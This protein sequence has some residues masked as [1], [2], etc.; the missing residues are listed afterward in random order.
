MDYQSDVAWLRG[1]AKNGSF[2]STQPERVL[3]RLLTMTAD[4]SRFGFRRL[5]GG[6]FGR[7][8]SHKKTPGTAY[9]VCSG[10]FGSYRK[11][12]SGGFTKSSSDGYAGWAQLCAE[13]QQEHGKQDFLPHIKE[14]IH[15]A[16]CSVYV[17][18]ILDETPDEAE[19]MGWAMFFNDFFET[20]DERYDPDYN[21]YPHYDDHPSWDGL[22]DFRDW[23]A[24]R[25]PPND[26]QWDIHSSNIMMR[27]DIPVL[28]DPWAHIHP[29]C[30]Q[31]SALTRK[32]NNSRGIT[33]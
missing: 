26:M 28:T 30:S 13:Y 3:A 24:D 9:K 8:Y 22:V 15:D 17:M 32:L 16:K 12:Y 20:D 5:G 6:Y 11:G 7:V 31:A 1:L 27:G 10:T 25:Q 23:L 29:H 21:K 33:A 14:I 19:G 4:H 18:D 2:A